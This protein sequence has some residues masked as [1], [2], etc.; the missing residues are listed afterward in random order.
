MLHARTF[1]IDVA[2]KRQ[3]VIVS[4]WPAYK[5]VAAKTTLLTRPS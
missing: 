3:Q 2:T 1:N 4:S 5:N